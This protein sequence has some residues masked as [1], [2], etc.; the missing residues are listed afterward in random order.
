MQNTVHMVLT[1]RGGLVFLCLER[2]S[3]TM[4]TPGS[5]V[6]LGLVMDMW[7][8]LED[9]TR[10]SMKPN[11]AW[12]AERSTLHPARADT[13]SLRSYRNR[14]LVSCLP[15]GLTPKLPFQKLSQLILSLVSNKNTELISKSVLKQRPNPPHHHPPSKMKALNRETNTLIYF[16]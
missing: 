6:T 2:G 4:V 14:H 10:H 7:P 9:H 12:A 8:R 15:K 1:I 16:K 13:L 11:I 3:A 5:G